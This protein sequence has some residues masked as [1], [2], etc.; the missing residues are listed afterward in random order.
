MTTNHVNLQL[1]LKVTDKLLWDLCGYAREKSQNENFW[2]EYVC[3]WG[4]V[5]FLCWLLM[6]HKELGFCKKKAGPSRSKICPFASWE[7]QCGWE[8]AFVCST[9]RRRQVAAD[10]PTWHS[11]QCCLQVQGPPQFSWEHVCK[12]LL[13]VEMPLSSK[14]HWLTCSEL[15]ACL[16]P[17]L[18]GH[19]PQQDHAGCCLLLPECLL[20]GHGRLCP[21]L[22]PEMC[23]SRGSQFVPWAI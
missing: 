21:V 15:G 2:A 7:V 12:W 6:H 23:R 20:H 18:L 17:P 8:S 22:C 11:W 1:E 10:L 5:L 19:P 4:I 14:G 3:Q 13:P 9:E 16:S